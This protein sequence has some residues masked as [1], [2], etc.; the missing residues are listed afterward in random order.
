M[1]M[2]RWDALPPREENS[3]AE[4]KSEKHKMQVEIYLKKFHQFYQRADETFKGSDL[5]ENKYEY[6]IQETDRVDLDMVSPRVVY[7]TSLGRVTRLKIVEP[8]LIEDFDDLTK[9]KMIVF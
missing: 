3:T 2:A 6:W 9:W 1:E 5:L 4:F 8:N 7:W